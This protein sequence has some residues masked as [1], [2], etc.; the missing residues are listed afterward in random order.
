MLFIKC[1]ENLTNLNF[2]SQEKAINV[3]SIPKPQTQKPSKAK[4]TPSK[5]SSSK[6]KQRRKLSS[7]EED[8]ESDYDDDDYD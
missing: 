1:S 4:S 8:E 7:S 2:I 3:N 5:K 6:K